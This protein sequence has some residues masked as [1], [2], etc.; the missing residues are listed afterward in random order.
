MSS[1]VLV[2][3]ADSGEIHA[4]SLDAVSGRLQRRQVLALGGMLMPMARHPRLRCLYVARR[5]E[6]LAV[7]TLAIAPQGDLE[8]VHEAPLP[9]SMAY[10]SCDRSGRWLLSASYGGD[11]VA[12]GPVD[13][14]GRAFG[15]DRVWP[16]GR[17]AHC[18]V[19]DPANRFVL[20]TALGADCLHRY[21]FDEQTGALTPTEPPVIA[22]RPGAGPRHLVFNA[23]GTRLYLLNELDAGIDV[24]SCEPAT[25]ALTALQRVSCLPAGFSGEPWAAELRLS[26]DG[27]WLLATERRSSTLSVFAVERDDGLLALRAQADVEAQPRGM[28]LSPDGRHVLVAGQ[29]SHHLSS[30]A[31][32]PRT[33][34]LAPC[35]RIG[36]GPGPNWIET[37]TLP[38][39]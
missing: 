37:L 23:Q 5:S 29:A 33:G 4:L 22:V 3:C 2:S 13:P 35:D 38:L 36:L 30:L 39:G 25:G 31:L 8:C 9:E 19:A 26:P 28:Q 12:V 15:A 24:F 21:L 34:D 20:A 11:C 16:T 1:L 7:V 27:R 18:V 32:D 10:L 14:Q 6:P 17:H